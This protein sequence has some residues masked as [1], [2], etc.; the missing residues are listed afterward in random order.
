M[1]QNWELDDLKIGSPSTLILSLILVFFSTNEG[2][3]D[4]ICRTPCSIPRYMY[5]P[6]H[7]DEV[8]TVQGVDKSVWLSFGRLCPSSRK[9]PNSSL[10]VPLW[11]LFF[12]AHVANFWRE[13]TGENS[14]TPA[15]KPFS[16]S[17]VLSSTTLSSELLHVLL[18]SWLNSL[19]ESKIS[20]WPLMLPSG[21]HYQD[22]YRGSLDVA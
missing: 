6:P 20:N 22:C 11:Q 15:L 17:L 10:T 18:I 3:S 7:F 21:R 19:T 2:F 9:I 4:R 12:A 13:V 1:G 16:F 14:E 5:W 8:D